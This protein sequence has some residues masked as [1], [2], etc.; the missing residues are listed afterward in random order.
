MYWLD[1]TLTFPHPSAAPPEGLLAAGGDLS[2]QR[3][4]LA[5]QYGIFPWFN[6]G[7]PILWWSPDP[8]FVLYPRKIKVSK[9]MRRILRKA[10]FEI[11][12]DRA[13]ADVIEA[14]ASVPR[15]GQGGT[16]LLPEMQKAY[17][18]LHRLGIAHSVEVWQEGKLVGGLYGIALGQCFFGESMFSKVSNASKVALIHLARTLEAKNFRLID[19]QAETNHL[20]SMGAEFIPRANFLQLL[21]KNQALGIQQESWRDWSPIWQQPNQAETKP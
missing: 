16:W 7:E 1:E 12:F 15:E 2:P 17:R 19:C 18:V 8:R 5:Y 6:E 10:P 11:T 9:S 13:F 20:K 4:V 21:E 3:L 14:C